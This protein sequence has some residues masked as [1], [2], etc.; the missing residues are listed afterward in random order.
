MRLFAAIAPPDKLRDRLVALQ[1][2]LPSGRLTA[3]ENLHLSLAF[4]GELD[5]ARAEDLHAAL[6]GVRAPEFD[7]TFDGVG[8]FGGARP[9]LLYAG[10]GASPALF[11]LHDRVAQAARDAGVAMPAERYAPHVTLKRLK[12]GEMPAGRVARWLA[13]GAGFFAGPVPVRDFRLYRSTLGRV[14]PVYD[15]VARYGLAAPAG[16]R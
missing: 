16:R 15:E 2:G 11:H 14:A 6:G 3:W 10:V 1:A 7:L 12:P 9:R 5:G 13:G 4:F 8:A